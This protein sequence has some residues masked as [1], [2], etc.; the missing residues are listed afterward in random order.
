[1]KEK[2]KKQ[3]VWLLAIITAFLIFLVWFF[4]L[5][6]NLFSPLETPFFSLSEESKK[7]INETRQDYEEMIFPDNGFS[8]NSTTSSLE[9]LK[10]NVKKEAEKH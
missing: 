5:G 7:E 1:M 2:S 10:E 6:K 4:S 3:L 9:I 8:A